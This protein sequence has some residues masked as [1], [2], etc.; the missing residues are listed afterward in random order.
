MAKRQGK[1]QRKLRGQ[2]CWSG[3]RRRPNEAFSGNGQSRRANGKVGTAELAYRPN[4]FGAHTSFGD[5]QW[6]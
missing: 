2:F 5:N 4:E 6:E 1:S 3:N